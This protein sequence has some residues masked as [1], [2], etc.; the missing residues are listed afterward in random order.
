MS[1]SFVLVINSGSSSLKFA[2]ID[3]VTGD[4]FAKALDRRFDTARG[5]FYTWSNS[6]T[7]RSAAMRILKGWAVILREA[8]D[9]AH[10]ELN[11]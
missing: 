3:S 8:L 11:D 2:V 5:G 10:P 1:N 6:V 7:N 4:V 9:E